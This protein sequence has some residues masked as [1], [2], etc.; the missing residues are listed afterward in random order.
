[1]S[2][3]HRI[4]W[5]SEK[6]THIKYLEQVLRKCS[7]IKGTLQETHPRDPADLDCDIHCRHLSLGY[8]L[9][10][11]PS[12]WGLF[13]VQSLS[14]VPPFATSWTVARQASLSFTIS[15]SLLKFM[16]YELVLLS[17]RLILC[18]P[19]LLLPSVLPRIRVFSIESALHIMWD[20]VLELQFQHWFFQWIFRVDFLGLTGLLSLPSKALSRIFSN[21][22]IWKHQ[23]FS[24]QTSLWF[25]YH[26]HTWLLEKP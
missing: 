19:L 7:G 16:S 20:K 1:M 4:L 26:I 6:L 21:T 14:R 15:Q 17:N 13:V 18:H 5:G 12:A 23:F 2:P 24:A 9:T 10:S 3:F 22:T 8:F 11:V 25:S